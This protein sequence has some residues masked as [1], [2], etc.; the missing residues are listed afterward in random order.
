MWPEEIRFREECETVGSVQS[1]GVFLSTEESPH[2]QQ[3]GAGAS[4]RPPLSFLFF[5]LFFFL[6]FLKEER[7]CR[8]KEGRKTKQKR[9]S[10][11]FAFLEASGLFS[12]HVTCLK[13][14]MASLFSVESCDFSGIPRKGSGQSQP[15]AREG[16]CA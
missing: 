11:S 9:G 5:L 10:E 16:N 2:P 1:G 6:N 14:L 3:C 8:G 12:I 7:K 13:H 15:R 4:V